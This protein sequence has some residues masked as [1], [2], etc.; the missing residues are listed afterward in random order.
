MSIRITVNGKKASVNVNGTVTQFDTVEAAEQFADQAE[1]RL[2][3]EAADAIAAKAKEPVQATITERGQLSVRLSD[4]EV[5]GAY[6]L[7]TLTGAQFEA[8]VM[9]LP[10]IKATYDAGKAAGKVVMR[11]QDLPKATAKRA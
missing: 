3:Q 4:R 8:L 5:G 11:W 10:A 7:F 2:A 6:P 1:A 9:H